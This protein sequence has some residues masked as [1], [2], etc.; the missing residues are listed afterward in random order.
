M[1][2]YIYSGMSTGEQEALELALHD[3]EQVFGA[4]PSGD[5]SSDNSI[6]INPSG[7]G[8][9]VFS[10]VTGT[11]GWYEVRIT[12]SVNPDYTFVVGGSGC[13]R[14]DA[15]YGFLFNSGLAKSGGIHAKCPI[16]FESGTATTSGY[17]G[18]PTGDA[19]RYKIDFKWAI[20]KIAHEYSQSSPPPPVNWCVGSEPECSVCSSFG[21]LSGWVAMASGTVS[22]EL[23]N[24]AGPPPTM[25]VIPSYTGNISSW[26]AIATEADI[27]V[28]PEAYSGDASA[29]DRWFLD[30]NF[31]G[32]PNFYNNPN[33]YSAPPKPQ[34]SAT[35]YYNSGSPEIYCLEPTNASIPSGNMSF[36]FA[37]I[38]N[39]SHPTNSSYYSAETW[40]VRAYDIKIS[41]IGDNSSTPNPD[42]HLYHTS[43]MFSGA[44]VC[45]IDKYF[46]F[47]DCLDIQDIQSGSSLDNCQVLEALE[48]APESGHRIKMPSFQ[49]DL[50]MTGSNR[51]GVLTGN[52][53]GSSDDCT[54]SN[55]GSGLKFAYVS[56]Y[57]G[58]C[59]AMIQRSDDGGN[60]TGIDSSVFS[61]G[62]WSGAS[63]IDNQGCSGCFNVT[64]SGNKPP[65]GILTGC[66]GYNT[67]VD[68]SGHYAGC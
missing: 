15:Y 26:N 58:M 12:P 42:V 51:L 9:N 46:H 37:Q 34:S 59:G 38:T 56:F 25:M 33:R 43:G 67:C 2:A 65:V 35:T 13:T 68:V 1:S 63:Y 20:D 60:W 27:T 53:G 3:Y 18:F 49:W 55:V 54:I 47:Y 64:G 62:T 5:Y 50:A 7:S 19:S 30:I 11:T 28:T 52:P 14:D 29:E 4:C 57:G 32:E 36:C 23:G 44:R 6:A 39:Q 10:G 8:Y 22:E 61:I 17:F 45:D 40:K 48:A 31:I 24:A 66:S 41:R 16:C 21:V